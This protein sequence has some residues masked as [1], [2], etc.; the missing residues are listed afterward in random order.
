MTLRTVAALYVERKGV[1]AGL[2]DVD[3]WDES[4]D[5]RNYRGPHPV[6]AHPPCAAWCRLSGLRLARYGLPECEDGGCFAA[7]LVAVQTFGG[8]L[9]HPAESKAWAHF[10]LPVPRTP[11]WQLDISGAWVCLVEQGTYGHPAR[12]RTWLYAWGIEPP[13]MDWRRAQPLAVVASGYTQRRRERDEKRGIWKKA[14]S[15]TPLR[16]ARLLVSMARTAKNSTAMTG[17][18]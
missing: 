6:V 11:G 8:V 9:E 16:F 1:Y 18:G 14:V 12:K 13:S 2:E 3:L 5:A 7:A 4:R 17:T 10:G 15:A